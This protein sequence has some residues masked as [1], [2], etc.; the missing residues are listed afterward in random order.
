M[1]VCACA[2]LEVV[3][4]S[5]LVFWLVWWAWTQFTWSLNAADTTHYLVEIGVLAATAVAF[6]MA[7]AVPGA[8]ADRSLWFAVTYVLVR[9]LGLTLYE[10][11]ASEDASQQAAVRRFTLVSAGGLFVVLVGGYLGGTAQYVLWGLLYFWTWWPLPWA[12]RR[13]AGTCTPIILQSATGCSS[14]SRWVR[15]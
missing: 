10:W 14:S 2:Y 9:V 3:G 8:F 1:H 11:V 6:F 7:V 4:Q 12:G 5:I 15:P 13:R